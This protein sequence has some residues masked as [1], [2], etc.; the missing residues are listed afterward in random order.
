[1]R[2]LARHGL[3]EPPK[4]AGKVEDQPEIFGWRIRSV[5]SFLDNKEE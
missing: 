5:K 1:M 2:R 3:Y 4:D